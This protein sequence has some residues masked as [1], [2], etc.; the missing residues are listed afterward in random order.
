MMNDKMDALEYLGKTVRV[1]IDR[2]IG[3]RKPN[4][5]WNYPVNYGYVPGVF[6]PDGDELDVFVLGPV[7]PLNEFEGV[8]AAVVERLDDVECKLVVVPA[9]TT[10]REA[11]I[12]A[13]IDFVEQFFISRVWMSADHWAVIQ[14]IRDHYL[15]SNMA[16]MVRSI[17]KTTGFKLK[18][19]YELFPSGPAKGACK[20]AG[21]P[22][23]DGCV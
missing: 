10:W 7:K 9:G 16:P 6:A 4:L 20:I 19:I 15:K 17:C 12:R 5:S 1:L 8:C 13:R 21:L 14:F 22:K 3:Y 2:P 23:P 11:E 18:Y